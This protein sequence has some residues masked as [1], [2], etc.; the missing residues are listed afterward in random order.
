MTTLVDR[1]PPA[2][3][4]S[5]GRRFK[6]FGASTR[7]RN[8]RRW[9]VGIALL[10]VV[11]NN[12]VIIEQGYRAGLYAERSLLIKT[13]AYWSSF[14]I[15]WWAAVYLVWRCVMPLISPRV[16]VESREK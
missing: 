10:H 7:H 16:G 6:T 14:A 2:G 3:A 15:A 1:R 9:I 4:M 5:Y 12:L 13:V 8:G 11:A